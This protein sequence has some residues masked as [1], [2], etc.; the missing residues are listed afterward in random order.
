MISYTFLLPRR[1]SKKKQDFNINSTLDPYGF[2]RYYNVVY[3]R[4][5]TSM[6]NERG[7]NENTNRVNNRRFE[8]IEAW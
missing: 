1:G 5:L 4:L 2:S 8:Q 3:C 7:H 6:F